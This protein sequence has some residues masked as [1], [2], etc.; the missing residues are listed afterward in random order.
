MLLA[1]LAVLLTAAVLQLRASYSK[2]ALRTPRPDTGMPAAMPAAA[3]P[4]ETPAI[5][6]GEPEGALS[7]PDSPR[8]R[9]ETPFREAALKAFEQS[10]ARK[11]AIKAFEEGVTRKQALQAFGKITDNLLNF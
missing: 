7:A 2:S 1:F 11:E 8:A 5:L 9:E 10:M 6:H 3:A 4:S